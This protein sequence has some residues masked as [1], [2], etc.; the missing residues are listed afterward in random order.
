MFA[1]AKDERIAIDDQRSNTLLCYGREAGIN[2]IVGT[3]LEHD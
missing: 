3:R 1:T 2:L